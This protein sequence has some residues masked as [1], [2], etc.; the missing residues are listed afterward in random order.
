MQKK[1]IL[2]EYKSMIPTT[3]HSGKSKTTE[4]IKRAMDIRGWGR[5]GEV[6][7]QNTEDF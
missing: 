6:N 5:E 3:W 1:P 7:R 2:K 4:T